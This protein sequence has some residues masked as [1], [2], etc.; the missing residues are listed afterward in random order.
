VFKVGDK[1]ICISNPTNGLDRYLT[2]GGVYTIS[3][4]L[5]SRKMVELDGVAIGWSPRMDRFRLI[6]PKPFNKEDWM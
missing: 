2:K 1:V 5:P 6:K 4:V 3:R